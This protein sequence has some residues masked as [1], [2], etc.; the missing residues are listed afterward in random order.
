MSAI[1]APYPALRL[2]LQV[3]AGILCGTL[4]LVPLEAWLACSLFFFILLSCALF[5]EFIGRKGSFPLSL[6]A[7][8]YFFFRGCCF[9][10]L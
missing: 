6:T 7:I 4:L 5:Y 2:L 8:G 10:G 9:C 1:F 3:I